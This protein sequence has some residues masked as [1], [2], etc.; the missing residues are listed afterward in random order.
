VDLASK[1][2]RCFITVAE[3]RSFTRAAER[4]HITQP[5]LSTQVRELEKHLGFDL[6]IRTTRKIDLTREGSVFFPEARRM[7]AESD[8]LK[9]VIKHLFTESTR[10]L[11]L[12]ASFYTID[13]PERVTL[14]EK[15]MEAYPEVRLD[16][17]NRWQIDLVDDLAKGSLDLTLIIGIPVPPGE[18]DA[19]AAKNDRGEILYPGDL[20]QIVLRREPVGLLVPIESA[21]ALLDTIPLSSL[22]GSKIAMLA[23][24]HGSQIY[25][26]IAHKLEQA[27]AELVIPPEGNGIGVERYGRQFR[28]PAVTLGWFGEHNASPNDMVRRPIEDFDLSTALVLLAGPQ[29]M[30]RPAQMF[31]D[32]ASG[33]MP[34]QNAGRS[35]RRAT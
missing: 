14:I 32:F 4:L 6:F 21:L 26:P 9:G 28:I 11:S 2:L 22:R 23:P 35:A 7:V 13:I 10:R 18:L 1:P 15:F 29:N 24:A 33:K 16:I 30:R 27:G 8:R 3:E 5:T 34:H 19:A 17:D 25:V 31:W 20:K 12:G